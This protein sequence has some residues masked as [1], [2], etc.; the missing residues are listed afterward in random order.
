[1]PPQLIA[2]SSSS[3][4]AS[5]PGRRETWQ[6]LKFAFGSDDHAPAKANFSGCQ[7]SRLPGRDAIEE[8]ELKA[9]NCGGNAASA[10]G[11]QRNA[12]QDCYDGV[13]QQRDGDARDRVG[14]AIDTIA[15]ASVAPAWTASGRTNANTPSH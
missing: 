10:K 15:P 2:F 3:S 9:I 11:W 7:V 12:A 6:P 8:L 14:N 5:L 13:E 4:I 1:L